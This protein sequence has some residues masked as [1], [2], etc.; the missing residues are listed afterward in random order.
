MTWCSPPPPRRAH[1]C[2]YCRRN[3]YDLTRPPDDKSQVPPPPRPVISTPPGHI[4]DDVITV[5]SSHLHSCEHRDSKV[6]ASSMSTRFMS[7]E[8]C[9]SSCSRVFVCVEVKRLAVASGRLPW[10]Q[11]CFHGTRTVTMV[12]EPQLVFS[13][14]SKTWPAPFQSTTISRPRWLSCLPWA[15]PG[16]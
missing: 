10:Y 2:P 8:E 6:S 15:E 4:H 13:L 1:T 12:T 16:R 5:I 3:R 9:F 11:D 14:P 7:A